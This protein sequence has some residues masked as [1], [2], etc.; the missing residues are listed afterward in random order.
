MED[1]MASTDS[2]YS[3]AGQKQNTAW[4]TK[5]TNRGNPYGDQVDNS[6]GDNLKTVTQ[7]AQ[8]MNRKATLAG[9]KL[10]SGKLFTNT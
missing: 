7:D 6:E 1:N 9:A 5:D 4:K 8:I 10:P 2:T 3:A